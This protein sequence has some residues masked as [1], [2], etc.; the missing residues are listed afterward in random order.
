ME[1]ILLFLD[2]IP[3]YSSVFMHYI[4]SHSGFCIPGSSDIGTGGSGIQFHS[5]TGSSSVSLS[6]LYLKVCPVPV[7]VPLLRSVVPDLVQAYCIFSSSSSGGS[8]SGGPSS[9]SS[10]G[11][12]FGISSSGCPVLAALE[13]NSILVLVAALF[14]FQFQI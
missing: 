12:V 7:L 9:V 5:G 8:G 2:E 1:N 6:V 10:R 4:S 14:Q 13:F 11:P 3:K